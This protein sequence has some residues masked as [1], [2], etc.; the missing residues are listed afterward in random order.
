MKF[1]AILLFVL[2][3]GAVAGNRVFLDFRTIIAEVNS[4]QSS[5]KAGHNHYFDGMD[6]E[7]IKG[8]MGA[9]ETP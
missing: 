2:I 8:L 9:L 7:Q 4:V 5:W 3:V 1:I 6:L